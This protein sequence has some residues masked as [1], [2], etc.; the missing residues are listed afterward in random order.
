MMNSYNEKILRGENP[1]V[2][3]EVDEID[4]K[5]HPLFELKFGIV[6]YINYPPGPRRT[7]N[8]FDL[9]MG[10]YSN[11]IKR[12]VSTASGAGIQDWTKD[13]MQLFHNHLLPNLRIGLHWGYGF[14]DGKALDSFLFMFHGYRPV[15]E[16]GKA[17][18]FRFEFPWNIDHY[19]VKQLAIDI[20]KIVPFE[21][22]FSGYFFKPSIQIPESYNQ[23][24]AVCR[25]F[26]GVEAWNLDVTVNYILEGYKSIN[27]LTLI[28]NSLCKQDPKAIQLAKKAAVYFEDS[29]HGVIFQAADSALLGDQNLREDMS[30]YVAIAKALLPLQ[31]TTYGSFGGERWD[32][33]NSLNWIRRFTHPDD[34]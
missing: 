27:W 19:E 13:T 23:M 25:R 24:F 34:V 17:S 20:A 4:G 16:I 9:Y 22:G 18:F 1:F 11:R 32:E 7:R 29:P 28:G 10:R 8:V 26:W 30:S 21:S 5:I 2:S 15:Q 6:F 14:D 31:M 3:W 33:E 12:Y